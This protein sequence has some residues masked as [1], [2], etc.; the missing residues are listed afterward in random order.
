MI[1]FRVLYL[2]Y[3]QSFLNCRRLE[4]VY[5][6]CGGDLDCFPIPWF[7]IEC[8]VTISFQISS[9][10]STVSEVSSLGCEIVDHASTYL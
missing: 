6:A 1:L 2:Q 7:T 10:G 8:K 3:N 4:W 5:I 9:A